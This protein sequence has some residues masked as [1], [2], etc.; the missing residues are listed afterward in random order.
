MKST[1]PFAVITGASSGIGYE[2][3]K[4][5]A[6]HG[7][8]LLLAA[9]GDAIHTVPSKLAAYNIGVQTV[10]VDLSE[11]Q[12]VVDLYE[13]IKTAD[14][15]VDAIAINAGIGVDG[16]FLETDILKEIKLIDLNVTCA[17][18]LAKLVLKDMAADG[19]G[20]VLFT[21]SI[22]A[23]APAPYMA[24]YAASK[25]FLF[26]FAVALHEE[27]KEKGITVTALMPGPT[28]TNFFSRADMEDT[29]AGQMKKDDPAMVAKQGF[30]ALMEG[31]DH[32]V[33]SSA[34]VKLQGFFSDLMP[35]TIK[36]KMHGSIARPGSAH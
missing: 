33:A 5:F 25:A 3:A 24:V 17:V 26:S 6:E 29:K 34:M 20:K 18:Y 22:A 35:E 15:K 9:D 14:R 31:D 36:A 23:L 13:A 32:V 21:S 7:Y 16:F 4:Q 19:G 30:D 10:Q 2:L 27:L 12:G 28:D 1:K 11:Q 8:D